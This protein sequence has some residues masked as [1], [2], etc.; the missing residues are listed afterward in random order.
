M[1][2]LTIMKDVAIAKSEFDTNERAVTKIQNFQ[3]KATDSLSYYC[4][5]VK[6]SMIL[7]YQTIVA[8]Q[9]Y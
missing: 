9:I 8:C 1:P 7:F 6:Y 2:G 3:V 4:S 5:L